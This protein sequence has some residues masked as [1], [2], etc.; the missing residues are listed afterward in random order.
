MDAVTIKKVVDEFVGKSIYTLGELEQR[1]A[2]ILCKTGYMR[3]IKN[4][5][6]Y[7]KEYGF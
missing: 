4:E 7:G 5:L 2:I 3:V 6:A 1:L